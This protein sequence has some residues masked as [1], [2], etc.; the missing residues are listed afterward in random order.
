VSMR[1][2]AVAA[3]AAAVLAVAG[4]EGGGGG[5]PA[6]LRIYV[7]APLHGGRAAEG[8]AIED[9]A[10]LALADAGGKVGQFVIRGIYL[11]DS[12]AGGWSIARTA[13][14][15]R[16]AAQDTAAI[17]YVGDVDSGA[18]RVSLPITNQAEIA[19]VSPASGAVDL[20]RIPPVGEAE[21]DRYRPN[22]KQSFARVV[23]DDEV[24]ARA[25]AVWAKKTGGQRGT[26][27]SDGSVYGD[28]MAAAFAQAGGGLGISVSRIRTGRQGTEGLPQRLALQAPDFVYLA[29]EL[30]AASPLLVSAARTSSDIFGPDPLLAPAFLRETTRSGARLQ[31]ISS[32]LDPSQ[33]SP[34]GQKFVREFRTRYGRRPEPA[35]AYGYESMVLLLDAIRRAGDEGDSRAAVIDALLS[36]T[37]RRSILGTYSIDGNGDTTLDSVTGYRIADGLPVFPVK[38]TARR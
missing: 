36:T 17:G 4:C 32:F 19:Q 8:Q 26:V 28:T 13:A 29:T 18:T 38:L 30:V 1:R 25:A 24:Q 11:D 14:N 21:P 31:L 27:V 22:D 20:T 35:A 37:E 12:D 34:R 15:A 9:G 16:Q 3:F 6:T 33:L 5:G 7:S 23:P 10:R 2:A